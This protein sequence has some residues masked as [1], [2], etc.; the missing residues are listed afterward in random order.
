ME[1]FSEVNNYVALIG[2][3]SKN[4]LEALEEEERLFIK[5]RKREMGEEGLAESARVL[6]EAKETNNALTVPDKVLAAIP[7][8]SV[9]S[10]QLP[11]VQLIQSRY[12]TPDPKSQLMEGPNNLENQIHASTLPYAIQ[13]GQY[14]ST[15]IEL[16]AYVHM[17]GLRDD[18]KRHLALYQA[19]VFNTDVKRGN[20][21]IS[22][23]EIALE[24]QQDTN[25]ADCW[26]DHVKG[27]MSF[28]VNVEKGKFLKGL[29]YLGEAIT[30]QI[31]TQE[32]LH[33][34][35]TTFKNSLA[36]WLT[37]PSLV[38]REAITPLTETQNSNY[39][40]LSNLSQYK[41]IMSITDD[42][43]KNEARE[44][45]KT[46][47]EI[48]NFITDRKR[49]IFH[50]AGDVEAVVKDLNQNHHKDLQT[51]LDEY[52]GD[53]FKLSLE[54]DLPK[55]SACMAYRPFS[56]Y[57]LA[58][59]TLNA[60][61]KVIGMGTQE[62]TTMFMASSVENCDGGK[63]VDLGDDDPDHF[64]LMV[65]A[66]YFRLDEGPVFQ[67]IRGQGLAYHDEF[68]YQSATRY[69]TFYVNHA[70]DIIRIYKEVKSFVDV[71]TQNDDGLNDVS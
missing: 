29:Q 43:T 32:R 27:I 61:V 66:Q 8:P 60:T 53:R 35:M 18:L 24:L 31:F 62:L 33:H 42:V 49:V 59:N 55:T 11:K 38:I 36:D 48:N 52:L 16:K 70:L 22:H 58:P 68:H 39:A 30:Q 19:L 56:E 64:T 1:S 9:D 51:I 57:R 6:K 4:K 12:L 25:S 21:T 2:K 10:I 45:L 71:L 3:P 23:E 7:I 37:N 54:D 13:I 14:D 50:M 15:F 67:S 63:C 65:V 44:T 28:S 17:S 69:L 34:E 46:F 47:Q 40:L 5:N 41:L 26:F 20:K